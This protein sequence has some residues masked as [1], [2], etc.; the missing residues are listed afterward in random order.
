MHE[1]QIQRNRHRETDRDRQKDRQRQVLRE[2]E[3][4]HDIYGE[5]LKGGLQKDRD[6]GEACS[7]D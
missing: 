3:E 2:R 6:D 4:E 7:A 5:K 1:T